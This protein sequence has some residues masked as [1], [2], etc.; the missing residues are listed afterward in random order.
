MVCRVID[1]M[2]DAMRLENTGRQVPAHIGSST[3]RRGRPGKWGL[4]AVG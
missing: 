2:V 4:L 3:S 1:L